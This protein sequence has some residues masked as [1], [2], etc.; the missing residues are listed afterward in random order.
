KAAGKTD[1][2][3]LA[4]EYS[5]PALQSGT[6]NFDPVAAVPQNSQLIIRTKDVL[7]NNNDYQVRV[8][9]QNP[10]P[11]RVVG[12]GSLTSA[13]KDNDVN[14]TF[15]DFV[16]S[17]DISVNDLISLSST[18]LSNNAEA[19]G[20]FYPID[21]F[22]GARAIGRVRFTAPT[23][24]TV[25][26]KHNIIKHRREWINADGTVFTTSATTSGN[27]TYTDPVNEATRTRSIIV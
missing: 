16:I 26:K 15:R 6:I 24:E 14:K 27:F 11:S 20:K 19:G 5:S 3:Y 2:D 13:N 1:S 18:A 10:A 17:N 7:F 22:L 4:F 8:T 12:L 21:N 25:N 23:R 9:L